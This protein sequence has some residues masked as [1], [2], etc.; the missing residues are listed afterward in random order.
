ITDLN[1]TVIQAPEALST[2]FGAVAGGFSFLTDPRAVFDPTSGRFIVTTDALI[3]NYAGAITGSAV[4][5][6]ISG[7]G[8]PSNWTFGKFNTTYGINGQSTWGDQP[9]IATNGTNLYV[10]TAQFAVQSGNYVAD[11]VTIIP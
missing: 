8:G 9:T 3:E 6:A 4:L 1:G 5:Y 2:F 11:A 7:T 10:T